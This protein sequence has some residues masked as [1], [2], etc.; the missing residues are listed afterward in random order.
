MFQKDGRAEIV[1]DVKDGS[2]AE[3]TKLYK[4]EKGYYYYFLVRNFSGRSPSELSDSGATVKVYKND[5]VMPISV[6]E[7]P[8]GQGYFWQPFC[9]L[10]DS[11]TIV[12]VN[13][14]TNEAF[15]Y[16]PEGGESDVSN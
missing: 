6:Y 11:G 2:E 3:I 16:E 1:K 14:I 8:K 4:L 10:G 7:V 13:M 5:A 12:P 9:I 15:G